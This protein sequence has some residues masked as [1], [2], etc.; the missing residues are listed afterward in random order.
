MHSRMLFKDDPPV[1]LRYFLPSCRYP[2]PLKCCTQKEVE[3]VHINRVSIIFVSLFFIAATTA[4][5]PERIGA[6]L[7][8][9]T[10]KRFNKGDTGNPGLTV[11]T[12]ISLDKRKV[13]HIVPAVSAF[14][15]LE[16]NHTSYFTKT[17]MFHGDLDFQ[18]RLF[19]EKSLKV[20]A[21]AGINYRHII[22]RNR[23]VISLPEQPVDSTISGFGPTIGATLEMR[24]SAYWDFVVSARYSFTGLR[25]GD[26]AAGEWFLVAPLASPVIQVQAVYYFYSRGGGYSY[27]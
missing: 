18:A 1:A 23:I 7:T 15:P 11:K 2:A 20:A 6:G 21:L 16:V 24:M 8:F 14:I 4:A 19:R 26:A 13:F 9:A 17:Y 10:K 5:Q 12:W 22:S 27:R 3:M 25:A